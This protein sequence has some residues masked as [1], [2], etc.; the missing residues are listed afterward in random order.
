MKNK[1]KY[2][3]LSLVIIIVA[4]VVFSDFKKD[5]TA[6][7]EDVLNMTEYV[8]NYSEAYDIDLNLFTEISFEGFPDYAYNRYDKSEANSFIEAFNAVYF[9]DDYTRKSPTVILASDDT[10]LL[11]FLTEKDRLIKYTILESQNWANHSTEEIEY[12]K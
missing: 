6:V 8:Q 5:E 1:V 7:A 4:L 11:L 2:L 3:V 9:Q 12:K 10:I